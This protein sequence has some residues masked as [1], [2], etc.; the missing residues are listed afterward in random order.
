MEISGIDAKRLH[1]G[2]LRVGALL[3]AVLTFAVFFGV[4][5]NQF[6]ALDDFAYIVNNPHI[7]PF[8]WNSVAWCFTSFYE[9]N[10]HPLAMLSLA[11]DRAIWGLDPFGYHLSNIVFH[12]TT[13][14]CSVFL[15]YRLITASCMDEDPARSASCAADSRSA[16]AMGLS[17]RAIVVGSIAGA[18]FFGLHPLRVESVAWASERKDVLCMLFTTVSLWMYVNY[19]VKR[20]PGGPSPWRCGQYRY[21]LLLAI[22]A[23][24]SKP[25]AVSLPFVLC[26]LD[27]YPLKT[28]IDLSSFRRSLSDKIPFFIVAAV[29]AVLTLFAQQVAMKYSPAVPLIS[30]LL[31]ACKALLFY[32]VVT[33]WPTGLSAFYM[34]PGDIVQSALGEY[35]LYAVVVL[36][37]CVAVAF[38]GRTYRIWPAL[39]M[40][41]VVTITPMLGVIQVGGQWAADRYSYLPSLGIALL[42]GG[43]VARIGNKLEKDGKSM[44]AWFLMVLFACQLLFYGWQTTRQVP[45]WRSTETLATR[46]IEQMP[47]MSSAPYIARAIYRNET[48]QY[49]AAL[50]DIGE[51]MKIALRLGLRKTYPEIALEQAVI[52]K[53]LARYVEALSILEWGIEVS[54]GA[55]PPDALTLKRDLLDLTRAD[56]H[57]LQSSSP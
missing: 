39:W 12:C 4:L 43:W 7:A 25:T 28:V 51:A 21:A 44:A 48:G 3:C 34:H 19:V 17:E 9:G 18:L 57:T 8:G 1:V 54:D 41:Y 47:H 56:G 15:F 22:F 55:A 49:E 5:D 23:Q 2:L 24:M 32:I 31:L 30:R 36:I 37:I 10:W 38:V 40:Y 33:I 6:V 52:L 27:W 13:V 46:I 45:V 35:L 20:T 50:A 42:W 16:H 29:G 26:I 53:N 14:F 11:V